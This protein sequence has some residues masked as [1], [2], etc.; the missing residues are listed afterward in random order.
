MEENEPFDKHDV[1]LFGPAAA[2]ARTQCLEQPIHEPGFTTEFRE[3]F[4]RLPSFPETAMTLPGPCIDFPRFSKPTRR[5]T[6][7]AIQQQSCVAS[8]EFWVVP[9]E[10]HRAAGH[11]KI[12]SIPDSIW[13]QKTNPV[14]KSY[15]WAYLKIPDQTFPCQPQSTR[16]GPNREKIDSHDSAS[17]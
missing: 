9:I 12:A 5:I 10:D 17:R 8:S 7:K 16:F 15:T 1:R 2:M 4:R 3:R 13:Q 11:P 6:F 14:G